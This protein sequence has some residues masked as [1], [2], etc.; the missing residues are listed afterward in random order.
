MSTAHN[1][2]VQPGPDGDPAALA[3]ANALLA[4]M[5]RRARLFGTDGE[6][7]ADPAWCLLLDLFVNGGV[8]ARMP[9]SSCGIA[10]RVPMS[11]ALRY[12]MLAEQRGLII[13]QPHPNDRRSALVSLTATGER[14]MLEVLG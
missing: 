6:L 5:D 14:L 1:L 3:K 4:L 13:R 12:I 10:S 2:V 7:F 11:T 9:V 8:H